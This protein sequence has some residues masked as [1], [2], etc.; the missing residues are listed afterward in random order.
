MLRRDVL[1]YITSGAVVLLTG[2]LKPITVLAK[3][4]QAAFSADNF[5]DAINAYF[6]G[7]EIHATDKIIIGVHPVVENGAVVPVKVTTDLP[8]VSSITLFVD[9]NPNPLIANFDLSPACLGFIST[10]IK[11]QQPSNIIAVVKSNG[12]VFSNR[13]FVEVHEGGCG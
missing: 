7:Q 3:W 13:T 1:K 11:V 9:K 10:R 2:L 8:L 4:N 6:P 12:E 5:E